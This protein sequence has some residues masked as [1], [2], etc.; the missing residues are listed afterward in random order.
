M[1]DQGG[2]LRL[3]QPPTPPV[4]V[5][6]SDLKVA[7]EFIAP[8]IERAIQQPDPP[9]AGENTYHY[10]RQVGGIFCGMDT[11]GNFTPEYLDEA[12]LKVPSPLVQDTYMLEITR[13]ITSLYRLAYRDRIRAELPPVEWLSKIAEAFCEIVNRGIMKTGREGIK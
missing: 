8:A 9:N 11:N 10:F 4:K 1:A 3:R 2:G 7:I 12:M 5:K 6:L 13:V